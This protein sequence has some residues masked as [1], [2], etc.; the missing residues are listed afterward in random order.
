MSRLSWSA[1]SVWVAA[2]AVAAFPT[3]ELWR[4]RLSIEEYAQ[5][6]GETDQ[7]YGLCVPVQQ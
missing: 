3:W 1:L 4:E 6:H 5:I 2:A 7:I